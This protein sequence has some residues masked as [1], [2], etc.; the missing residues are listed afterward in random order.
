MIK[1]LQQKDKF[2]SKKSKAHWIVYCPKK[3][4]L[5]QKAMQKMYKINNKKIW[6]K[7]KIIVTK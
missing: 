7:I 4:N 1:C 2:K 5:I 3:L 6:I